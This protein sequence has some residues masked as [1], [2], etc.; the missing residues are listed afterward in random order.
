ML[1]SDGEDDRGRY[2][3]RVMAVKVPRQ[4]MT[5][6]VTTAMV[7]MV[8]D[9]KVGVVT[10]ARESSDG[11]GGGNGGGDGGGDGGREDGDCRFFSEGGDIGK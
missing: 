7:A 3:L 1:H 5:V 10:A 6:E 4:A 11:D 8:V 2:I 9:V